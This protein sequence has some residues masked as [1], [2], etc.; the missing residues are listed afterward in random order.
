MTGQEKFDSCKHRSKEKEPIDGAGISGCGACSKSATEGYFCWK[1]GIV[2]VNPEI[3][4][5]CKHYI[6]KEKLF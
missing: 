1:T 3:C 2:D 6:T 5:N 4:E